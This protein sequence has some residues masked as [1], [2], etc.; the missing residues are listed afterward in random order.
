MLAAHR[1]NIKT[2]LIPADNERDLA[3]IPDNI[4]SDLNILPV[5]WIDEVLEHALQYQPTSTAVDA[6]SIPETESSGEE[7]DQSG[8]EKPI[9]TH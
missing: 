5:R 2:V 6:E 1:G 9:N 8:E 3:D 7:T 4:K